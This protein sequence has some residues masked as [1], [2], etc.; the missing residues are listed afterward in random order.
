MQGRYTILPNPPSLN[1]ATPP[2]YNLSTTILKC[3]LLD[4]HIKIYCCFLLLLLML[5]LRS[6]AACYIISLHPQSLQVLATCSA[7]LDLQLL[8]PTPTSPLL[9]TLLSTVYSYVHISMFVWGEEPIVGLI[10]YLKQN[11]MLSYHYSYFRRL[12]EDV[13]EKNSFENKFLSL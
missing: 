3:R 11:L 2:C 5:L 12:I 10:K 8:F 4:L 7:E 6:T 13:K 1:F 9:T